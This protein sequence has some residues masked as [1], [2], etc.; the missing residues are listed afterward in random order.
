LNEK[1]I[2]NPAAVSDGPYSTAVLLRAAIGCDA[3]NVP[4]LVVRVATKMPD[5]CWP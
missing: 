1:S 4:V 2:V 3:P 5:G